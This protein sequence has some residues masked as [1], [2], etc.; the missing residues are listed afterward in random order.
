[1]TA[2]GALSG[3]MV[4]SFQN[5]G[6][7]YEALHTLSS[8]QCRAQTK[9]EALAEKIPA[10]ELGCGDFNNY[11]CERRVFS[12]DLATLSHSLKECLPGDLICV[13]VEV[14]QFNT[15]VAKASARPEQFEPGGDYNHEEIHCYHRML[16]KG[17]ALFEEPGDSLAEA[18][19]RTMAACEAAEEKP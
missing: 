18:L 6:Q 10:R 14:R 4:F 11:V 7:K 8:Q 1:M 5:C 3:L 2:L 12:P 16:Y 19:A 9:A 15:T 13:D 17:V